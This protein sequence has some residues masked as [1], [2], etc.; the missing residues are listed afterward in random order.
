MGKNYNAI[1][2][3]DYRHMIG[4]GLSGARDEARG[5]PVFR[6]TGNGCIR[7]TVVALS[8]LA[9]AWLGKGL[10]ECD[11][12][13]TIIDLCEREYVQSITPRGS[14]TIDWHDPDD[15][16]I[17]LVNCYAYSAL[18][19]A[20]LARRV[21]HYP[22]TGQTS[23]PEM[24]KPEYMIAEN[25]WATHSGSACIIVKLDGKDFLR[26]FV[27]VSGA[28]EDE[29]LS[30]ALSGADRIR[31]FFESAHNSI[32][33]VGDNNF[34]FTVSPSYYLCDGNLCKSGHY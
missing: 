33:V 13:G 1:F 10:S 15:N 12:D 9:D 18:K 16:H 32:Y 26:L 14:H 30:C 20:Y 17:E 34:Q 8:Q 25:G 6:D 3:L 7:I 31:G 28:K 22:K 27:C 21:K 29:D 11:T 5:V 23:A 2:K 4:H 24:D 19:T